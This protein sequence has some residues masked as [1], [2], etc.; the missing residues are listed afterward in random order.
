MST[1]LISF[2]D[3]SHV[4]PCKK[5]R[6]LFRPQIVHICMC[7]CQSCDNRINL[8]SEWGVTEVNRIQEWTRNTGMQSFLYLDYTRTL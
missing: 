4:W 1:P 7:A 8:L 5:R 2:A 6:Q 3:L